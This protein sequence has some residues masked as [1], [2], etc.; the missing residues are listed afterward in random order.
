[1]AWM[2]ERV[3]RSN[4]TGEES[5]W[6]PKLTCPCGFTHNLTPMP[7]DGWHTIRDRDWEMLVDTHLAIANGNCQ[8]ASR[9][10]GLTG[11]LYECPECRRLMWQRP[12]E[13]RFRVF[14]PEL[15]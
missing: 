13:E 2:Q 6:M 14:G 9:L 3:A 11:W 12:G 5:A 1:M 8:I 10:I 4:K 7:D 15:S